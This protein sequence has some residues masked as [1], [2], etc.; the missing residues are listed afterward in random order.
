MRT[1]ASRPGPSWAIGLSAT[2]AYARRV[3]E[4]D[5]IVVAVRPR[6]S[7]RDRGPHCRRRCPGYDLREGRRRWRALDLARLLSQVLPETTACAGTTSRFEPRRCRQCLSRLSADIGAEV[8]VEERQDS[9]PS[10]FGRRVVVAK[11]SHVEQRAEDRSC[12]N[13][14]EE[15]VPCVR[16]LLHIVRYA[17]LA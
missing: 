17:Q 14:V 5:A 6:Y 10:V 13:P 12:I 7:Q 9:P 2:V 3:D 16:V 8:L 11:S 4:N 15:T 1:R